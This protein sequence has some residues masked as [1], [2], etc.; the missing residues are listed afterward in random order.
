MKITE[1]TSCK[2]I[3]LEL[4]GNTKNE[5]LKE[6][7]SL[8]ENNNKINSYD[9]FYQAVIS[10]ESESSTG[11][12]REIAIPHGKSETVNELSF[13]VGISKTGVDF[14]SL[15]GKAVKLFFMIADLPGPSQ[16]YL[17]LLSKLSY[18]LRKDELRNGLLN[19][20][21]KDQV[22]KILSKF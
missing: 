1:F 22:L 4:D 16:D 6:L 13:A 11:L 12:G 18:G 15:D 2:Q 20:S 5:V 7:V 9:K 19:A 14:D 8:L 21:D 10:R 3:K 17:K